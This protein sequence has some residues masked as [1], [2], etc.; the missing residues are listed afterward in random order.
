MSTQFTVPSSMPPPPPATGAYQTKPVVADGGVGHFLRFLL[1]WVLMALSCVL[2]V[3]I[4]WVMISLSSTGRRK[5]D[6]L[7]FLIPVWGVI[8]QIQTLW[9]YSAK[10]VYWSVRSDRPSKSLFGG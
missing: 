2:V 3:G 10:N 8:L 5:R 9:R 7:M 6:I 1:V 4:I